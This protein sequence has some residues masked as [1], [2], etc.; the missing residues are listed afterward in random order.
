M[1]ACA[2]PQDTVSS[3]E[4]T[5]STV[6]T[7]S[8]PQDPLREAKSTSAQSQPTS[9]DATAPASGTSPASGITAASGTAPAG[10]ASGVGPCTTEAI[11]R[12]AGY[13]D[14]VM[15]KCDGLWAFASS[16]T[17]KYPTPDSTV[18]FRWA[19]GRWNTY[20]GFPSQICR[21]EAV[22]DGVPQEFAEGMFTPC[23]HGVA[24][25]SGNTAAPDNLEL[26]SNGQPWG[27]IGSAGIPGAVMTQHRGF[28]SM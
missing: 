20:S 27:F 12:D 4:S 2:A 7:T 13:E 8:L 16:V 22:M 28:V 18:L 26:G 11:T 25:R 6:D 23:S 10:A 19:N 24:K 3:A 1:A 9:L 5:A 21:E 14:N 17:P 15:G